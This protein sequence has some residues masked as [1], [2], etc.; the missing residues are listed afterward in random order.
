MNRNKAR[1]RVMS[2][3]TGKPHLYVYNGVKYT[4][5]LWEG[6]SSDAQ[7]EKLSEWCSHMDSIM[8]YDIVEVHR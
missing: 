6:A 4:E 3:R 1:A 2:E 8:G 7:A 5:W